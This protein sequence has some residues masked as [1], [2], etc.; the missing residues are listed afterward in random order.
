MFILRDLLSL[1]QLQFSETK[2]GRRRSI[3]FSY[4]LLAIIVPFT[5]SITSNLLRSLNTLF[6][7]SIPMQRFYTFMG[8]S[9]LPW[10]RLWC[11]LWG[12]IPSPLVDGRLLA[13]LDDSINPKSGRKIFGCGFFHDHAA[14]GNQNTF[15]W[16][17]CI[18]MLGLLKPVKGRWACLPLSFCFYFMKADVDA[19]LK[20]ESIVNTR[21]KG[22]VVPFLTKLD[23]AAQMLKKLYSY[24][25][26]PVLVVAD[27]WFGNNG[28]WSQLKASGGDFHLLSR[29]RTNSVLLGLPKPVEEGERRRGRPRKYGKRLGKVSELAAPLREHASQYT[30][31]LYGRRRKVEAYSQVVM[32][33][34]LKQK[35]RVVWV[36]RRTRYVALFTTDLSLSVEQII[37]YYG[38]RWK[39]E[40]GFKEIKQEIGSA[41]SQTR[42]A[43]AV[44]NHLQFCMMATSLTWIYA[45]RLSYTP[46]R[47]HQVQGRS[48]F[49]FSDVRRM[50]AEAALDKD[51]QTLL[52]KA[53]QQPLNSFIHT[54]LRMVA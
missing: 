36:Y 29:L 12:M 9:T 51:F 46:S 33:K 17:Q 7:F 3:W 20:D 28:L 50:I 4:T 14:K 11:T 26:V 34:T 25:K 30:V 23:Q 45:D 48:S 53:E 24:F 38:A 16:S 54:L 41:R 19:A 42:N 6:G 44:S 39:I 22:E 10:E 13:V 40:S 35:I 8:S 1:L 5:S 43:Q 21:F 15:P 52:P 27:S 2:Q 37:A 18:L 49:A 32:V 31:D 47:R